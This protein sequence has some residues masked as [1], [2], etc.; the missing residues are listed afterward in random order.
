MSMSDVTAKMKGLGIFKG[1]PRSHSWPSSE[2]PTRK[3]S[4]SEMKQL[5][6]AIASRLVEASRRPAA[7][8]TA[9]AE[10]RAEFNT[11]PCMLSFAVARSTLA[12]KSAV[13]P[14]TPSW[15]SAV[16][17]HRWCD[18]RSFGAHRC[19]WHNLIVVLAGRPCSL[20]PHTGRGNFLTAESGAGLAANDAGA[21]APVTSRPR[22]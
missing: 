9:R 21:Q 7:S 19:K 13:L 22:P 17:G 14:R 4:R 18:F 15:R 5:V 6:G 20:G 11:A 10:S 3:T 8:R 2:M 1:V 16:L 12:G